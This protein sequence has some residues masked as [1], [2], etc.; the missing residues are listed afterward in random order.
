MSHLLFCSPFS[1]TRLSLYLVRTNRNTHHA[2]IRPPFCPYNLFCRPLTYPPCV[3]RK[4]SVLFSIC[5]LS[6]SLLLGLPYLDSR[7]L[8]GPILAFALSS[9]LIFWNEITTVLTLSTSEGG[10]LGRS[11]F[12]LWRS[13]ITNPHF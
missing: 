12:S 1:Q 9:A 10:K 11:R 6:C 4:L 7:K 3:I 13:L 5:V 8:L 2:F